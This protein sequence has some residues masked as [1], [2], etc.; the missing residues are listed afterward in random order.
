LADASAAGLDFPRANEEYGRAFAL[1]PGNAQVSLS[2]GE[3]AVAMGHFDVGIAA[4]RRAV[5]LDPLN[6]SAHYALGAALAQ[7]RRYKE[8]IE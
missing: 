7:A 3:F 2:Y 5:V 8:A 6:R 4:A 1:A